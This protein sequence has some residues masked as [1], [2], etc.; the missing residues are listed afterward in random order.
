MEDRRRWPRR[1]VN[2]PI[3][4]MRRGVLAALGRCRNI[5]E[6]GM[7]VDAEGQVLLEVGDTVWV[8]VAGDVT[9]SGDKEAEVRRIDR[10][11]QVTQI[12]FAFLDVPEQ[13]LEQGEAETTNEDALGE[14]SG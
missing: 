9:G 2:I 13:P 3:R 7:C 5:G 10:A 12:A 11:G 4:V 14:Q 8:R 1:E 6:G